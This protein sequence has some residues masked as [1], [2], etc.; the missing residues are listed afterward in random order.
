MTTDTDLT[1]A[2]Q[3]ADA[4]AVI[5]L[6]FFKREIGRWSK[7]DGSLATEADVAVERE[8][9]RRFAIERPGDAFLGEEEGQS[10]NGDRRWIVDAI[11]GTIGFAGGT[12]EWG[13]LIALESRGTI[14]VA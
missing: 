12:A 3:L 2:N 8:L 7:S 4:A 13:T 5:S 14:V 6:S 9:R 11:D 1:L 10:G